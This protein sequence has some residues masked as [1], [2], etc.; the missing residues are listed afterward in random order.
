MWEGA[1]YSHK[2]SEMNHGE[3]SSW[4]PKFAGKHRAGGNWGTFWSLFF[5]TWLI[6]VLGFSKHSV[7]VAFNPCLVSSHP[8]TP[9]SSL[10]ISIPETWILMVLS[11]LVHFSC[12]PWMKSNKSSQS[13]KLVPAASSVA[14]EP[15]S[16][17]TSAG[18]SSVSNQHLAD[19][20]EA[21]VG[22]PSCAFKNIKY[23]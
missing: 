4:E 14:P 9:S 11:N 3:N 7:R 23:L 20:P 15:P 1:S 16:S 13:E 6:P 21:K 8:A 5:N 2:A 17:A 18:K 22:K 12:L 19:G 10:Q